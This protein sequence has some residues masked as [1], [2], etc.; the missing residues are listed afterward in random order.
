MTHGIWASVG[1]MQVNEYRHSLAANNMANLD[2]VGFKNDLAVI[3]QRLNE[4]DENPSAKMF[5]TNPFDGLGGGSWVRPTYTNFAQGTLEQTGRALDV[6]LE[7]DGFFMVGDGQEV[8]YT[9]DGR[10]ARN[11]VGDLVLSADGGRF[12]VLDQAGL[13][14]NIADP[15][16]GSV[17]IGH[18]GELIQGDEVLGQVG[19]VDFADRT[20]LKKAGQSTFKLTGE[21]QRI[22]ASVD[23][24]GGSVE[25]STV[26]SIAS[27][28]N[29]IEVSRAY[30]LNARMISLQDETLGM[31]TT[32]IGRVG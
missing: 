14:I 2:T 23:M 21:A 19:V 11:A 7:G 13:P 32:R 22:P 5:E 17:S 24:H 28:T 26:D 1:G 18:N 10:F 27:L 15:S 31:A 30:E 6:A 12:R 25:S 9:R 20:V 4:S 16:I 8:R 29:M 3:R